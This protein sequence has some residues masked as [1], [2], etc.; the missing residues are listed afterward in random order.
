MKRQCWLVETSLLFR[1]TVNEHYYCRVIAATCV[2][3]SSG[4]HKQYVQASDSCIGID[5]E[6]QAHKSCLAMSVGPI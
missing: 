3:A 5:G 6:L 1:C 2:Q 4:E